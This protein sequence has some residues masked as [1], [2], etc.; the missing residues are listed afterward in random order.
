MATTP[1][2]YDKNVGNEDHISMIH[3]YRDKIETKLYSICDK[4]LKLLDSRLIPKALNS[5]SN[6][7]YLKMKGDYD[8]LVEE[9]SFDFVVDGC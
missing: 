1:S 3:D 5:D 2:A 6:V 4:I 7:F 9:M 8:K